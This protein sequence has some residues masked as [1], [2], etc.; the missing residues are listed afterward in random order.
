LSV[1]VPAFTAAH[2]VSEVWFCKKW[3]RHFENSG[4]PRMLWDLSAAAER[5]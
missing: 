5:A 2:W 3:Q 1:L 4:V